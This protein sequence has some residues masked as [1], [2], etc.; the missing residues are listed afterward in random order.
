[1]KEVPN[2]ITWRGQGF[3]V[4][5]EVQHTWKNH[6]TWNAIRVST[7][8]LGDSLIFDIRDL[9]NT[10]PGQILFNVYISF[11]AR[12]D[13]NQQVWRSGI[14][15]HS[16]SYRARFRAKVLMACEVT[17]R[18]EANG[19]IL[20]DAVFRFRVVA[21]NVTYDNLVVE[22]AAGFGGTAAQLLGDAVKG[23]LDQWKPSL[24]RDMLA[25]ANAAIVKAADTKEVRVSLMKL[26]SK[27]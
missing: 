8:S 15:L 14:R 3:R 20:P 5:P 16:G 12:A 24:E 17:A 4:H 7:G 10:Q 13:C 23:S 2:G 6:G 9:G 22:H 19:T 21:A 1:M 11:D 18:L 25:K 26:L 27:K